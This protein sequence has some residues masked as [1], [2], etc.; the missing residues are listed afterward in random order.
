MA[1]PSQAD[2]DGRTSKVKVAVIV[3]LFVAALVLL[4]LYFPRGQRGIVA[5]GEQQAFYSVDDG[6]NW[7]VDGTDKLPPFDHDGK[8]AVRAYVYEC[9]GKKYVNHL[10]RY[11]AQGRAVAVEASQKPANGRFDGREMAMLKAKGLE[12]K[13]P[14]DAKWVNAAD[15]NAGEIFTPRCPGGNGA[16]KPVNP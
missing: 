13:R 9:D 8:S 2:A 7:F 5:G 15:P 11:T 3:I 16:P 12:V 14:G 10:Q 6:A 4:W 1:N